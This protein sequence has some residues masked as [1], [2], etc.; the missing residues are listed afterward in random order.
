MAIKISITFLIV[1]MAM[2]LGNEAYM[3][4]KERK[5]GE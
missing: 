1:C 3:K 4:W 5:N 2:L